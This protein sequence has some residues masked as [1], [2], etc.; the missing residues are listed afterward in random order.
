MATQKNAEYKVHNGTDF[1]TINFKTIASQVK[2]ASGLDLE[3]G[4]SN[5]KG[6]TGYTKLPNG[7]IIQ[8]GTIEITLSSQGEKIVTAQLPVAFNNDFLIVASEKNNNITSFGM[9]NIAASKNDN[10]SITLSIQDLAQ[11]NRTGIVRVNWFAIGY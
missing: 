5:S 3:S 11:A 6:A 9:F 8:W 4:F 1:D 7:L 2:M 10:G